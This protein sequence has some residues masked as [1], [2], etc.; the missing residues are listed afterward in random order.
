M[1]ITRSTMV[2]EFVALE[3]D[4]SEAE[5]IRNFLASTPLIKDELPPVSIHCDS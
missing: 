4:G 1:I 3:L 5:W 2:P